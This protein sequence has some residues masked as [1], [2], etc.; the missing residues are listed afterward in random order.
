VVVFRR[1]RAI[2]RGPRLGEKIQRYGSIWLSLY[3]CAWLFGAGL[4]VQGAVM[5]ALAL[6]GII[7]M[8]VMREVYGLVEHPVG[9]RH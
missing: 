5:A 2:G 6:A 4:T 1:Y 8:I 9:Y 7:G 3:A